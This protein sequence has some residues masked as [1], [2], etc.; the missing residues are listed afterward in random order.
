MFISSFRSTIALLGA[1]LMFF[2][3]SPAGKAQDASEVNVTLNAVDKAAA[4]Q[5]KNVFHHAQPTNT[6]RAKDPRGEGLLTQRAASF[7]AKSNHTPDNDE[8]PGTRYPGDLGYQ[9]GPV[10]DAA[11][12]HAVYLLPNGKCPIPQCWGD[13]EKF[14]KELSNSRFIHLVDQYIGLAANE[15]YTRGNRAKL[16]YTPAAAPLTDNDML[17]VVHAVAALTGQTGYGHIFHIFLPPG[18]DECFDST[19]SV[20]YSPDNPGSFFFCA[21]HGSVD[22]SDIGHVLYSVEP[23]Q[24]VPGCQVRPGTPNGQL[25]DSTNSTLSHELFETITDPDIDAWRNLTS[26]AL[27][28]EEIGDECEFLTFTTQNVYFDPDVYSIG[29]KLYATQPEYSNAAHGCAVH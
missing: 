28:L 11:E 18:Q 14:L 10:I 25:I 13:P 9:G 5:A 20:C 4:A 27:F 7:A 26:N 23:F 6:P 29:P 12:S 17:A 21:Y 3:F 24:N 16:S 22:F 8:N 15:R 1:G 19:F 2:G